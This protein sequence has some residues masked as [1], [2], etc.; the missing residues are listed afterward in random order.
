MGDLNIIVEKFFK[1]SDEFVEK[2]KN[3]SNNITLKDLKQNLINKLNEEI[4]SLDVYNGEIQLL[5]KIL[6]YEYLTNR[7]L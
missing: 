3:K 7:D 6:V 4:G 5:E 1:D 2:T